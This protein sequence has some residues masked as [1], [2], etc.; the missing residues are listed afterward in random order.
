MF[1]QMQTTAEIANES[2]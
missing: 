1:S 2:N